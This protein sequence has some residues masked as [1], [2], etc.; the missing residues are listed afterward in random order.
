MEVTMALVTYMAEDALVG[1]Q[2]KEKSWG[3]RVFKA[4]M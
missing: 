1:H 2:W 3:L 4:P